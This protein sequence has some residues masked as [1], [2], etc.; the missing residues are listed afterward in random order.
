MAHD[1]V[2]PDAALPSLAGVQVLV[3]D[4]HDD[5]RQVFDQVLNLA[6]AV[7]SLAASAR[8][9]LGYVDRAE[10]IVTD[11]AMPGETG[12]WLLERV[13]DRARPVPVI[14]VTGYAELYAKQLATAPFARVLRK[15]VDPWHLCT[16]IAAVLGRA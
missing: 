7:V 3:V 5:T 10:V 12:L 4:D 16:V 2:V 9:A 6:G 1:A 11:Y 15:P 14:V 8:E 13:Q